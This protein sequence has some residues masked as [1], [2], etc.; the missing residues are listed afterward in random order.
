M[1][2]EI[3]TLWINALLS[4]EYRQGRKTL[5]HETDGA[6]RHCCLGVLCEIA[7]Q[8]GVVYSEPLLIGDDDTPRTQFVATGDPE[9]RQ[10]GILPDAVQEWAGVA[11]SNGSFW[12][13]VYRQGSL[14]DLNDT[15]ASFKEIAEY[16]E[17]YF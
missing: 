15:G 17:R 7:E 2:P 10:S 3:K 14:T 8:A 12:S 9:D 1:N 5:R 4:G 11:N 6:V 16:I 13:S